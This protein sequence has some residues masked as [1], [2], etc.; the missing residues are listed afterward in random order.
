MHNIFIVSKAL[1]STETAKPKKGEK[2]SKAA[3][4]VDRLKFETYF[5]FR[6]SVR[7][8]KPHQVLAIN[9]GESLKVLSVKI[10]VPDSL[11][12]DL[13]HFV[14]NQFLNTGARSKQRQ[15]MFDT[16]FDEAYTKKCMIVCDIFY[17]FLKP[18]KCFLFLSPVNPLLCRQI[19][20]ELTKTAQAASIE[21]FATNLKQL[22]LMSPVKGE[23]IVGIDPGFTNGCKVAIISEQSMVLDTTVL[24]PHNTNQKLAHSV[25]HQ[26][27]N[28]MNKHKYEVRNF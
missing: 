19:H 9:R 13:Y 12:R 24:Y 3:R 28:L 16:S 4:P 2:T 27:A 21:V 22:L 5:D 1:K 20:G 26:L 18:C 7:Y 23:R 11:K 25:G 17:I 10:D 6:Q 14:R 8:V 15:D